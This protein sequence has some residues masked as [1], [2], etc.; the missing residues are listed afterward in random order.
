MAGKTGSLKAVANEGK[1][2]RS[3]FGLR[4]Q[5]DSPGDGYLG[6]LLCHFG[7]TAHYSDSHLPLRCP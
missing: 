3:L 2:Y 4:S 5:I 6:P 7:G 1:C